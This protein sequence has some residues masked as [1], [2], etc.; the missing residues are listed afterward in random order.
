MKLNELRIN[1]YQLQGGT[2]RQVS[3]VRLE[4]RPQINGPDLW[5]IVDHAACL[6]RDGDWVIE[7][8]PSSRSEDY[9]ES[10]RFASVEEALE[11]WVKGEFQSR[12]SHYDDNA[13]SVLAGY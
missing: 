11:F 13:K 7:P 10:T 1:E 5:A 8:M 2:A 12:F 3:D 4:R 9:L 6:V